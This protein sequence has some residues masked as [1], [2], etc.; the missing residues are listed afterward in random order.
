MAWRSYLEAQDICSSQINPVLGNSAILK[1]SGM[2]TLYIS[3]FMLFS[4][5]LTYQ[6]RFR[7]HHKSAV[8]VS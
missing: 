8:E 2:N 3:L 7:I 5:T 6:R 1:G 4:Y